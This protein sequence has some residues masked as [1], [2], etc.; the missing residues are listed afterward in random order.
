MT[1]RL[2]NFK[3]YNI[4]PNDSL[5][6]QANGYLMDTAWIRLRVR[7]SYTDTLGGFLMTLRIKPADLRVLNPAL[8]PLS[9]IKIESGFLDT[10][11]MRAVGREYLSLGE[12]KM[13]YHDLKLRMF[14]NGDTT[15]KSLLTVLINL[16]VKNK[17][18]SRTGTVFFIRKRDRSAINY[19]IKIALSGMTS[20]IGVKSNKSMLRKYKK[21]LERRSLPPIDFE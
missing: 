11:S 20:S 16:V 6:L 3:N 18:T 14:K 12:M 2:I 5:A 8:I 21:E 4:K 7:E 1:V 17:N 15:K 13:N 10:L 9:S 19:L